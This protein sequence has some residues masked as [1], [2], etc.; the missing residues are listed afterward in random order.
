[1]NKIRNIWLSPSAIIHLTFYLFLTSCLRPHHSFESEVR[2]QAPD[3]SKQQYWA[4][5][6]TIKDSADAL[7][8][9]A[10]LKDGQADAKVDVFFIYPTIYLTGRSWNADVNKGKLNR[11]IDE[12]TIRHQASAFNGSCKVYAPRYR[13]AVLYSYMDKKNGSK[14]LDFAYQDVK[15]AFE[16]YMKNYNNGRPFIIA[17]HSQ[18]SRHA[19]RLITEY[20]ESDRH[21]YKQLICAYI[22][23]ATVEQDYISVVPCDSANQ[24]GCMVSWR[25]A[26]WG[27]KG[28]KYFFQK[29]KFCTN[30]LSWKTDTVYAGRNKNGGGLPFKAERLDI[31]IADAKI[32]SNSL[33]THKPRRKGY[34]RNGKNYHVADYNLFWMNIR[35]NVKLRIDS[36]FEK[37]K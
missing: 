6:P 12:T 29:S 1:M 7:P 15:A 18:G 24:T 28:D 34:F 23:G 11:R 2:P 10:G 13:Q 30:P 14:A 20:F 33:W 21:L 32:S 37:N 4:A 26:R 36:Y 25:T 31:N 3:Y 8:P 17:S 19:F 22:I 27:T 5:L 9:D 16:Y 35:E